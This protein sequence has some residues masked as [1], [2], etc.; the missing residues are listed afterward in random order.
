MEPTEVAAELR[1]EGPERTG[2]QQP[3]EVG[4]H[5]PVDGPSSTVFFAAR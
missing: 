1:L 5:L 3:A 4:E 2:R